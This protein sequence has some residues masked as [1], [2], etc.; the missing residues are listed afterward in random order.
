MI[1]IVHIRACELRKGD[2]IATGLVTNVIHDNVS[3]K[4][5]V[6]RKQDERKF[7][8]TTT[9]GRNTTVTARRER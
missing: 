3:G 7:A 9:F 4:T 8:R 2:R 5:I 6:T 1:D